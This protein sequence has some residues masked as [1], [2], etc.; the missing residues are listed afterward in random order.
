[1]CKKAK[2]TYFSTKI[3]ESSNNQK[4]LFNIT[5][6]LLCKEKCSKL[7]SYGDA[8]DMAN[9]FANFF[10]QKIERIRQGFVQ[11]SPNKAF[12]HD[13]T[14]TS[15]MSHFRPTTED[16]L[17]KTIMSGNNKS[18]P[19]DPIPT[20][21]IKAS[22]ECLLPTICKIVNLSIKTSNFPLE[23]KSAMVT[24]LLKKATLDKENLQNYRPVSNLSYVSKLIEKVAVK[25]LNE[26]MSTNGLHE[27]LQ[28]A[29][30]SKHS[31]ETALVKVFND[32]LTDV[33]NKKCVMVVLLDLSAAFDTVDHGVLLGRMQSMLG[34]SGEVLDWMKSYLSGRTQSVH[35][36]GVSSEVHQ[37][38][39]GVPQGSVASPFIFP[40]YDS[41]IATIARKYGILFHLYADDSQLYLAFD[42]KDGPKAQEQLEA[43]IQEIR[44]WMATNFLK[45]NDSKTEFLVIG[46]PHQT[47]QINN[48]STITI[49]ECNIRAVSSARNIGVIMDSTLSMSD[50]ISSVSRTCYMHLHYISQIRS[51]L[52]VD[53][54]KKLVQSL[55]ISRLDNLNSLYFGLPGYVIKKLQLIQNN[56]ARLIMR[57]KKH[58]HITPILAELHWLPVQK[59][60]S[61]KILLL[62]Y[63]CFNGMAPSYL[64]ELLEPYAPSRSLRSSHQHLLKVPKSRLKTVG[65]RAFS[66][67]APTLWNS[68]PAHIRTCQSL[69]SFKSALKTFY[70]KQCYD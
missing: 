34:V 47:S 67:S 20:T 49:G 7:P 68:L 10:E 57:V 1:M 39:A 69:E 25:Q 21:L 3:E 11:T 27:P 58:S 37:L 35:V 29:Y 19:L 66:V 6:Q 51:F 2:S 63:K 36:E 43:C 38:D 8:R 40:P 61:Y 70:F 23:Y 64:E 50:H 17:R 15:N 44:S 65:D 5:K 42:V 30:R 60:I 13:S 4:Q 46:L 59:R 56:A 12:T 28:S 41:P 24:P 45:L 32:I 22:L 52:T 9:T 48:L 33:D 53:A 31:I 14:A 62:T 18:C 55:I 54:A 16:E 26:Y